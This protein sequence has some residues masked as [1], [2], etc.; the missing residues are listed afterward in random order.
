MGQEGPQ[1]GQAVA[2]G[3]ADAEGSGQ[4]RGFAGAGAQIDLPTPAQRG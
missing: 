1:P 4:R 2:Q 3:A